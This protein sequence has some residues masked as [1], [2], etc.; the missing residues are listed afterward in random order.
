[1]STVPNRLYAGWS[2]EGVEIKIVESE[3]PG[4]GSSVGALLIVNNLLDLSDVVAARNNLGLGGSALAPSGTFLERLS[5]LS[6]LGNVVTARTNL[7][8]AAMAQVVSVTLTGDVTGSGTSS[9][10]STLANTAVSA[11]SYTNAN[12]TVDAKGRITAAANGSSGT[13][14]LTD[15][16]IGFGDGS[17][18]LTGSADFIYN[19]M[20]GTVLLSKNSLSTIGMEVANSDAGATTYLR[21]GNGTSS[22]LSLKK[23]NTASGGSLTE[24][25]QGMIQNSLA[26]L[27]IYNEVAT[28]VIFAAGSTAAGGELMRVVGASPGTV[29]FGAAGTNVGKLQLYNATSGS[30]TISPPTGALGTLTWTMPSASGTLLYSGGALGTPASGVASNLTGL[31][32]T[33]GVTGNLPVTNLNSGTSASSSTFWR[34]DGTWATPTGIAAG[35]NTQLQFNSSGALAGASGL[36]WNTG[37][38]I[39]TT[40]ALTVSGLSAG[41]AVLTTGGIVSTDTALQWNDTTNALTVGLAAAASINISG[42]TDP[43]LYAVGSVAASIRAKFEN[44]SNNSSALTQVNLTNDTP[45]TLSFIKVSS[46]RSSGLQTADT[47]VLSNSAGTILINTSAAAAIIFA[48]GGNAAA[49]EVARFLLGTGL[50]FADAQN[51][52]VNGTTGTKIGT[53]TSQKLS[54]WNATPIIQPTTGIAASTFTANTSAIANDTATWDGYTVGQVVKA[55]RNFGLLA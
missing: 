18:L 17:N 32:L 24:T 19:N 38:S 53:A 37:T 34:G 26:S 42:T 11:G 3:M 7:G 44:T 52:V 47:G 35:S 23:T 48:T 40:P 31:P 54:L 46:T 1:M 29:S 9:I 20:G 43:I 10:A 27:L 22:K 2:P 49:N 36:T 25:N 15:T 33:T 41:V 14:S 39:L 21:V 45:S 16:Q 4:Y 12:I 30:G 51:I 55:L 50:T 6:D 13:P 8:L 28:D 5:N